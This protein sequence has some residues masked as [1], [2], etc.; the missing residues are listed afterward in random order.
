[1]KKTIFCGILAAI[2]VWIPL[3]LAD[4][5]DE[6]ILNADATMAG[7]VFFGMPFAMLA[8][9]IRHNRK[10]K[11]DAKKLTVWLLSYALAFLP[12]WFAFWETEGELII[13]QASH[14]TFFNFNGIE[15]MFYGFSA[16]C[17]FAA[18]VL[19]Y[20]AVVLITRLIMKYRS[21]HAD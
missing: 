15:Y 1:M 20:H 18:L 4:A 21:P 12:I 19:L 14:S 16:L 6:F 13:P 8:L 3:L 9:Y 17:A 2:A 11:P 10:E 7:L 5:F